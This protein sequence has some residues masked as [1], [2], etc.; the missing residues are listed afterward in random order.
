MAEK[1]TTLDHKDAANVAQQAIEKSGFSD[2]KTSDIVGQ[3][4]QPL[5]RNLRIDVVS[6]L[7]DEELLDQVIKQKP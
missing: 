7:G 5:R 4:H 3:P 1:L 2:D 6:T